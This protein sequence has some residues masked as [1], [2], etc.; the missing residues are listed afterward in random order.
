MYPQEHLRCGADYMT[1]LI[2]I[3]HQSYTINVPFFFLIVFLIGIRF[4]KESNF[5]QTNVA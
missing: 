3:I 1:V 2:A 4:Q 5:P